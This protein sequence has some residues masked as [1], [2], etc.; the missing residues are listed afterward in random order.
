[1][2]V[3]SLN[4]QGQT[5]ADASI[6]RIELQRDDTDMRDKKLNKKLKKKTNS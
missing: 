6:S 2:P 3:C 1:M 5:I 4:K